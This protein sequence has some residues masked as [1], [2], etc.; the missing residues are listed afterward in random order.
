MTLV[1]GQVLDALRRVDV[2]WL[3]VHLGARDYT[4]AVVGLLVD[5][6]DSRLRH[7]GLVGLG[8]RIARPPTDESEFTVLAGLLPERLDGPPETALLLAGLCQRLW[9]YIPQQRR[10]R[11]RAADLPVRVQIAWL[12]AEIVNEPA[13]VRHEPAGELLYQAL[14]GV[15]AL[16]AARP[17]DL[18]RE[19]ADHVDPVLQATAVRLAREA[20][21]S[22]LLSPVRAR[23]CLVRLLDTAGAGVAAT[24]LR[25]LAEPW[26]ALGPIP[27]ERLRAFLAAGASTPTAALIDAAIEAASRHGHGDL[28][29][30]VVS[31]EDMPP[32]SRQRALRALGDL[33]GRDDI[34]RLV[35]IA[36]TDPLLLGESA[37]ACLRAMHRRG[38]FP[39]GEDAVAVV[40]LAIA[41]HTIAAGEV[42]TIL[43]TCRQRRS[44]HWSWSIPTTRRGHGGRPCWSPWHSRA[45]T[46]CRSA[47]RSPVCCPRRLGPSP[48]SPRS[49]RCVTCPPR[50]RSSTCWSRFPRRRWTRWRPSAGVAQ[51]P[52]YKSG[53]V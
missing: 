7:L 30:D 29:R 48:S 13:T 26:A 45:A 4:P 40:A 17:E 37:V 41:D 16:D 27:R 28:L 3:T 22:G 10:P 9:G 6:H 49:G 14:R 11:W 38:V 42:A 35:A 19:L 1:D 20:L 33:V 39:S 52:R 51:P 46:T 8:T 24:A 44:G 21:H 31:D 18:V 25:E 15:T 23:E 47:T 53:S 50:L 36:A 43:F 5:H 2:G 34:G 32:G 12:R